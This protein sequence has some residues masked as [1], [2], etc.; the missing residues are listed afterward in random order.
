MSKPQ[1]K[2]H[3]FCRTSFEGFHRWPDAPDEVAFL[4]DR[5]RHI[6]HVEAWKPVTHESRDIEFILLKREVDHIIKSKLLGGSVSFW[7]CESWAMFL[8][9]ALGLSKCIVSEDGENGACCEVV[10]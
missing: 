1:Y 10:Q 3:V 7:S 2:M 5:H 6:F 9:D 8:A 4:R